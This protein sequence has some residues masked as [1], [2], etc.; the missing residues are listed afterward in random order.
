MFVCIS[1]FKVDIMQY[2]YRKIQILCDTV[3]FKFPLLISPSPLFS[4]HLFSWNNKY[5]YFLIET[6]S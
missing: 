1:S 5:K 3:T 4:L 6:N 2:V